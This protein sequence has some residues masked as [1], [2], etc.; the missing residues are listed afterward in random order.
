[1]PSTMPTDK[2]RLNLSLS[3]ELDQKL[4]LL[5]KRDEKAQSAKAVELI[6]LAMEIIEDDYFNVLAEERDTKGA[7]F[8]SHKEVWA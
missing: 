4:T 3:E 5:A 7:R 2:K 8:I 6:N 1:M